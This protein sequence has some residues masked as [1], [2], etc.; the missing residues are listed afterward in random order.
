M[1]WIQLTIPSKS[2]DL[3]RFERSIMSN[4][5]RAIHRACDSHGS[6]KPDTA[7]YLSPTV[8]TYMNNIDNSDKQMLINIKDRPLI[9]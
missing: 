7:I 1:K 4:A 6:G 3:I 9:Y 5:N 2:S 8:S